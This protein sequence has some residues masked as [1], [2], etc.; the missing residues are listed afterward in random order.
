MSAAFVWIVLTLA[1]GAAWAGWVA[2]RYL[3]PPAPAIGDDG[4]G[5]GLEASL[6][7]LR[8]VLLVA[9]MTLT[10]LWV[11]LTLYL[12]VFSMAPDG[13]GR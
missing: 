7:L 10:G 6:V 12:V 3:S 2:T 1:T 8:G 5:A 9:V 11:L 4:A 13:A